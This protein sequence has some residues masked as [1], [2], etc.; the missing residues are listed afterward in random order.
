MKKTIE[1]IS[2]RNLVLDPQHV[3]LPTHLRGASEK[4]IIEYML[5]DAS[6]VELIQAIAENGF[7]AGEQL[8]VVEIDGGNYKV[9]EGNR[10]ATAVKLL[11]NPELTSVQKNKVNQVVADA[12]H[13]PDPIPCLV[14]DKEDEIHKYLG[15]RHITGIQPWNLRQKARYLNYFKDVYSDLTTEFEQTSFEALRNFLPL[16]ANVKQLGKNSDYTG[17]AQSKIRALAKDLNVSINENEIIQ[18]Q[19]TQERGLDVI[20]WLPFKDQIPNMITILVQCAC[21]TEWY[22][23]QNKTKRFENAY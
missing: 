3:R 10:R 22:K 14:F 13:K 17:D 16:N 4:A 1:Y 6:T 23:K 18:I 2:V 15:Y 8:L 5:L 9:I 21:G 7:F 20:G 12:D 11:K 19:G